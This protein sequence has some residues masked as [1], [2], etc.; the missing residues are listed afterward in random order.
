MYETGQIA[1]RMESSDIDIEIILVIDRGW[2][3][4]SKART[5]FNP[6]EFFLYPDVRWKT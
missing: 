3:N 6:W 2:T 4:D 5:D 1:G